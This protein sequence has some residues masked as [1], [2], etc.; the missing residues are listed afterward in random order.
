VFLSEDVE[1]AKAFGNFIS[2]HARWDM[3][4]D[5]AI[6]LNRHLAWFNALVGKVNDHVLEVVRQVGK[7]VSQAKAAKK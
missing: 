1:K 3:T 2:K 7:P 6:M 5:E 4:T